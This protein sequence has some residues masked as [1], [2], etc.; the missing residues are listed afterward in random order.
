MKKY[1]NLH[2]VLIINVCFLSPVMSSDSS[3]PK[4]VLDPLASEVKKLEL[5]SSIVGPHISESAFQSVQ[6]RYSSLQQRHEFILGGGHNFL[7]DS[8]LESQSASFSYKFHINEKWS[9]G[10]RSTRVFNELSAA[11]E[12]LYEDEKIVPDNDYAQASRDLNITYNLFYGKIKFNERNI[13][14]FD[15]FVSLGYGD[16]E[17]SNG[18]TNFKVIDTGLCFYLNKY[19]TSRLSLRNEFY[20]QTLE[21]GKTKEALNGYGVFELGILL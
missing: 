18:N 9:M 6:T 5:P 1:I 12:R 4:T 17:L 14:H 8:H 16:I 21:S 13:T 3:I 19:F 20:N 10:L 15:G 7:A 11:G 2:L